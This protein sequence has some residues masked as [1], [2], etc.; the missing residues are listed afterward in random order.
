MLYKDIFREDKEFKNFK[1]LVIKI[2]KLNKI[3]LN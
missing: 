1:C 3:K 2:E